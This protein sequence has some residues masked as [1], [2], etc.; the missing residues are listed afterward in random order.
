MQ[1]PNKAR[2]GL[3]LL[4]AL[5]SM[6]AGP[7]EAAHKIH[8]F[9]SP[10]DGGRVEISN[11][12]DTLC[13]YIREDEAEKEKDSLEGYLLIE[14]FVYAGELRWHQG[15]IRNPRNGKIYK[16]KLRLLSDGRLRVKGCLWVFCGGQTWTRIED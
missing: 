2:S 10:P 7:Q 9:W 1:R 4:A 8:G 6:G 12:G 5:V 16:S 11:C 13:A 15:K 14:N 3:I